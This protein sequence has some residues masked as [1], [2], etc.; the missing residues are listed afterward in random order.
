MHC[1]FS[2]AILQRCS[3]P[4]TYPQRLDFWISAFN[5]IRIRWLT[6]HP[7][8]AISYTLLFRSVQ[9]GCFLLLL[10][11]HSHPVP[12]ISLSPPSPEKSEMSFLS[13]R[14]IHLLATERPFVPKGEQ[15]C[16][17]YTENR[18]HSCRS[19]SMFRFSAVLLMDFLSELNLLC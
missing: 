18:Q 5:C 7:P 1:L 4:P 2:S 17:P 10:M 6:P 12:S 14:D 13:R 16:L 3:Y 15:P 8:P 9:N 11:L 19:S